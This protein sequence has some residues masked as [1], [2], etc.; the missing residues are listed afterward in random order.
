MADTLSPLLALGAGALTI[1]SPCVLPLVP[2]VLG[3]AAHQ[4][5][6]GP[7]AL[8]AGLV[9]SFTIIGFVVATLGASTGFDGEVVRLFG[10]VLLVLAGIFLLVPAAQAYLTRAATPLAD[11]ASQRQAGLVRYGL[12]GQAAIGVLLGMVWSP[13]VGPTLGAATVLA[14][15]GENLGQVALV[16]FAFGLGIAAVLLLI[17]FTSRAVFTRWRSKLMAAGSGGKRALGGLLL[18][19]GVMIFTG[20][21]RILEGVLVSASPEWL[22]ELTTMI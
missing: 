19:V 6:F 16:M 14:A 11:W 5:R 13:C 10:A 7:L 4:H 21:D 15:Q 3:S 22:T 2:I 8:A 17:A 20:I 1:L 18:V 9:A 12:A